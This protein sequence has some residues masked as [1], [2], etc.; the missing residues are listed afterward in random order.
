MRNAGRPALCRRCMLLAN[1][2]VTIAQEVLEELR[3]ID[4]LGRIERKPARK[5]GW[6]KRAKAGMKR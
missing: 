3:S 5:K 6:T 1:E 2:N 4:E